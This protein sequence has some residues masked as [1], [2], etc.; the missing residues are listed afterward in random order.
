MWSPGP[1]LVV[2]CVS[3]K[4]DMATAKGKELEDQLAQF[5]FEPRGAHFVMTPP[6]ISLPAA[7]PTI[8]SCVNRQQFE[9]CVERIKTTNQ[10]RFPLEESQRTWCVFFAVT[11]LERSAQTTSRTYLTEKLKLDVACSQQWRCF[12][13]HSLL[14]VA[15]QIDHLMELQF[16]GVHKAANLKATC[17]TCH[18]ENNR[19]V[20]IAQ[21]IR[22]DAV[23]AMLR[24]KRPKLIV[25]TL[26]QPW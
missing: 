26:E 23:Q 17:A 4:L 8:D 22:H 21:H 18:V 15:F 5:T 11:S 1:Q 16:G 19:L 9:D 3:P 2:C 13:C 25:Q 10:D 7:F 14:P 24:S 12:Y 6:P 20:N